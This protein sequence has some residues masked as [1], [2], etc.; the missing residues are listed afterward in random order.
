M[1]WFPLKR[2]LLSGLG[3]SKA[4]SQQA[5]LP[6][7]HGDKFDEATGQV[8][9]EIQVPIPSSSDG[10][11]TRQLRVVT[12]KHEQHHVGYQPL[13]EPDPG[14][15]KGARS[16]Q[17][18]AMDTILDNVAN[19]SAEYLT[20]LPFPLLDWLWFELNRRSV[21]VHLCSMSIFDLAIPSLKT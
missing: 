18:Q 1:K 2:R 9:T 19:I 20:M 6:V 16:L 11:W 15:F 17:D 12:E 5:N 13:H 10:D 3:P 4:K 7:Q 14:P 8:Y 21:S